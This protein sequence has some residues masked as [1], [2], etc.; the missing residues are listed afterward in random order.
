[1]K[2]IALFVLLTFLL[3]LGACD[4]NS[5]VN[6]DSKEDPKENIEE[7]EET[8]DEIEEEE[9][10][11]TP[12]SVE[13]EIIAMLETNTDFPTFVEKLYSLPNTEQLEMDK[14]GSIPG[15]TVSDWSGVVIEVYEREII[16]Y[17]GDPALYNNEDWNTIT[18][19]RPELMAY[20]LAVTMKDPE[21][22]AK[23]HPGDTLSI[24]GRILVQ[25]NEQETSVWVLD[26]G[27]VIEQE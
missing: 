22:I 12:L 7:K 6:E 17:A 5:K 13:D 18:L 27:L 11:T 3:I 21:Q 8:Q 1:M 26:D 10:E 4:S 15:K 25:G 9:K 2:K 14:E 23:I 20:S 19:D 16:I 24:S